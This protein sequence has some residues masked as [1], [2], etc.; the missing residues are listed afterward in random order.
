MQMSDGLQKVFL[1]ERYWQVREWKTGVVIRAA[2]RSEEKGEDIYSIRVNKQSTQRRYPY[3]AA[4]GRYLTF[5]LGCTPYSKYLGRE[6]SC[7]VQIPRPSGLPKGVRSTLSPSFPRPA[8][9]AWFWKAGV[10]QPSRT[11]G[12][13]LPFPVSVTFGFPITMSQ[14]GWPPTH[15]KNPSPGRMSG[16][17]LPSKGTSGTNRREKVGSYQ[18]AL[19]GW[20]DVTADR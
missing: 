13:S 1:E 15:E 19:V 8:A 9:P 17:G 2:L 6:D 5:H 18:A 14:D 11:G 20:P 4:M 16:S 7:A 3:L 10:S 12:L